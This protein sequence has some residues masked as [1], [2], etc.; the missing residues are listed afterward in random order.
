MVGACLA[1]SD[2]RGGDLRY[3][4]RQVVRPEPAALR[5]VQGEEGILLSRV[6]HRSL[7]DRAAADARL[8]PG[9][10]RHAGTI[11]DLRS[12]VRGGLMSPRVRRARVR[13][14]LCLFLRLGGLR[15]FVPLTAATQAN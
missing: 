4:D 11:A 1:A 2:A 3:R 12:D 14:S 5:A 6:R 8:L 7:S 10:G 9:F 15:S 13:P